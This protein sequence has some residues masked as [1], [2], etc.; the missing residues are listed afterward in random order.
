[1]ALAGGGKRA[2]TVKKSCENSDCKFRMCLHAIKTKQFPRARVADLTTAM[3]GHRSCYAT[4]N[5]SAQPE[6]SK[7]FE[8]LH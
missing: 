4:A 1:V 3:D 8:T 7:S 2:K 6:I 5:M